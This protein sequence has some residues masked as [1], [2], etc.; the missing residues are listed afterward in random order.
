MSV[1]PMFLQ[2]QKLTRPNPPNFL[3]CLW[4]LLGARVRGG[5]VRPA[6]MQGGCS[7]NGRPLSGCLISTRML[8]ISPESIFPQTALQSKDDEWEKEPWS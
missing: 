6:D 2:S 1:S 4:L 8:I 7:Q 3:L 5:N